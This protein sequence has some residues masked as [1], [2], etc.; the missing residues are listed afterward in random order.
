MLVGRS[1]GAALSRR[2]L[3]ARLGAAATALLVAAGCQP[4]PRP[5]PTATPA[6]PKAPPSPVATAASP[7]PSPTA[8]P[9]VP[10]SASPTAAP[11]PTAASAAPTASP[12]GAADLAVARGTSPAAITRAAIEAIGGIGRFVPKGSA[13]VVKPNVCTAAAPE[14]AVCTNPEVVETVVRMC[15]EAGASKVKVFDYGW[16]TAYNVAYARSGI[17]DAVKRGGGELVPISPVKW[18][19]VDNPGGKLIKQLSIFEDALAADI[20]VNVPIAKQH[21]DTGLTL[22]MKNMMGVVQSRQPFHQGIPQALCDLALVVKPTLSVVDAVRILTRNG[23]GGGSLDDVK[24]LDTVLASA[25]MVA[26]DAYAS[27]LFGFKPDYLETVKAGEKSGL[28]TADLSKL[29]IAEVSR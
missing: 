23:P 11:R 9:A 19:K 28:G 12:A 29:K 21:G 4:A 15:V 10:T 22:A 17:E 16:G 3:I 27:T 14:Y 18:K 26:L 7:R 5:A 6:P 1:R 24:Q 8:A 2:A 13:V 20:I 25:D